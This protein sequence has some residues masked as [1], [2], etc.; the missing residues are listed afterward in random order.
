MKASRKLIITLTLAVAPLVFIGCHGGSQSE[1]G[2]HRVLE[3][4]SIESTR[5]T[6]DQVRLTSETTGTIRSRNRASIAPKVSGE[7]A[8]IRVVTGQ[9]VQRDELLVKITALELT[10]KLQS[11]QASVDKVR[12]DL[13]REEDLLKSGA[14]TPEMVN[15]LRDQLRIAE[16]MASEVQTILSYTEIR[17]PFDGVI[18]RKHANEGDLALPGQ[19][20]LE[21]ENLNALRVE[22]AIPEALGVA[23]TL[24]S[25]L[26]IHASGIAEPIV[27]TVEEIAPA[28]DPMSR[29]FPVKVAI[30]PHEL[31]KSGQF[32]KL[33]IPTTT[34]ASILV[35]PR[36]V[37]HWGQIER[38]FLIDDGKL[39]MRIVKTGARH[40]DKLE[41]LSGLLG[42]ETL[43]IAVDAPLIDGAPIR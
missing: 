7:I 22:A 6:L 20:M 29:T 39:R 42:N 33:R 15:D 3:P 14:S 5:A 35:D 36:A 17:A 11:A 4:V 9:A 2:S 31:L 21:I 34:V 1:H 38:V 23:L 41:V 8:E 40:G 43:A 37:T 26:E 30:A 25:E 16:A 32:V 18:T 19:P 10:S 28:A 12:R 24:G 27:G 13:R